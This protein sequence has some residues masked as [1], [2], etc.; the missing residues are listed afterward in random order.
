MN[1]VTPVP[2]DEDRRMAVIVSWYQLGYVEKS[3]QQLSELVDTLAIQFARNRLEPS[4]G[5]DG[6]H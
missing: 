1:D 5:L 6:N 2:T 3:L 4:G